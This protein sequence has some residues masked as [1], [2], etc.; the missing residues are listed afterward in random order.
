MTQRH[1]LI[2]SPHFPPINAPDHQRVRMSLP[3][4]AK[5]GWRATVLAVSPEYVEGKQDSMLLRTVPTT[6][7]VIRTRALPAKRTRRLGVGNLGLRALP[8]LSRAGDRALS[9]EHFDLV[10]FSTTAFPV[11]VLGRRW[12]KRWRVPYVLDFQDPW[13]SDYHYQRTGSPPGGRFRYGLTQNLARWLEHYTLKRAS[14]IIS[15]SPAYPKTLQQ[16]YQW[17]SADQFTVLPFGVAE[18]DFEL[19]KSLDVRQ[20]VFDPQDG[21]RH[22]VYVGAGGAAMTTSI[23]PFFAALRKVRSNGGRQFDNLVVHFVGTDYAAGDRARE[24]FKPLAAECGV[25]DVVEEIPNRIPYLESLKCLIDA[26]AL[27]VPGSDDPGYTAS[28]IYPYIMANKPMLAIFHEDSSVVDVLRAT[29]AGTLVTF[30]T[31]ADFAGMAREIETNW[32]KSEFQQPPGIDR[33]ALEPYLARELTRRQCAIFD[34]AINKGAFNLSF[35]D[36]R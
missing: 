18:N 5:C 26:E 17:L 10:F 16:R 2:V 35:K 9:S 7:R 25:A 12:L 8:F 29:K 33:K 23:K 13:L 1:V 31:K 6:T 32:F 30:K 19:V 34:R 20:R 3:Y 14:H 27:V 15:V 11:M 24:T 28:K 4:F 36:S 22:W 21:K